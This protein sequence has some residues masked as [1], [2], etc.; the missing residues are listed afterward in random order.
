M[1]ALL[2]ISVGRCS[3]ALVTDYMYL[4]MSTYM[5]IVEHAVEH[6]AYTASLNVPTY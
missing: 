3:F 4:K 6:S 5:Y 1:C 2:Q